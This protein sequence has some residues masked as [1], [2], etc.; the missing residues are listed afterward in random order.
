MAL[1]GRSDWLLKL[2]IT[3]LIQFGATRERKEIPLLIT[4]EILAELL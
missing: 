3:L 2:R 4:G 1:K